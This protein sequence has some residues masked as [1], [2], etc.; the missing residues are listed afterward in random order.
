MVGVFERE[1]VPMFY[2]PNALEC[3]KQ[4]KVPVLL[5]VIRGR[6]HTYQLSDPL[7]KKLDLEDL[8]DGYSSYYV[9]PL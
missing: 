6:Q 1:L 7:S 2:Q 5:G 3:A 8:L 9:C 4:M